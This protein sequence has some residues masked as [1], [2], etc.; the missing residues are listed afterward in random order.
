MY[1]YHHKPPCARRIDPVA[2][3]VAS[4]HRLHLSVGCRTLAARLSII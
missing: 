4:G 1:Y 3:T 2:G